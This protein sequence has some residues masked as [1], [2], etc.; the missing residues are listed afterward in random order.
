MKTWCRISSPHWTFKHNI[1]TMNNP[2]HQTEGVPVSQWFGPLSYNRQLP[3][4]WAWPE[5]LSCIIY[6][7]FFFLFFFPL[8][9][10]VCVC[11]W[12]V[13]DVQINTINQS[14][15][16]QHKQSLS[17]NKPGASA[18]LFF[19]LQAA[20]Q[21]HAAVLELHKN[22][23]DP[24]SDHILQVV[25]GGNDVKVLT[26]ISGISFGKTVLAVLSIFLAAAACR[27]GRN[28]SG[29]LNKRISSKWEN[30]ML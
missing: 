12:C 27:E 16:W 11:V 15:S 8:P 13:C 4:V 20:A 29:W 19:H 30:Y 21:R 24:S 6:R 3:E 9:S 28:R 22:T 17:H 26:Q 18:A 7:G 10:I 1:E 25:H 23:K 2:H 14:H 5:I